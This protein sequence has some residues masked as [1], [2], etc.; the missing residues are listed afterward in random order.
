MNVV[1]KPRLVFWTDA[2]ELEC[3]SFLPE[4]RTS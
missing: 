1:A 3:A 4:G 2:E